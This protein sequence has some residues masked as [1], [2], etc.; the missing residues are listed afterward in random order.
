MALPLADVDR[1]IAAILRS[2]CI[3]PEVRNS[4][5]LDFHDLSIT[6]IRKLMREAFLAGVAAAKRED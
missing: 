1:H 4:D 5:S 6:H 2:N 3:H